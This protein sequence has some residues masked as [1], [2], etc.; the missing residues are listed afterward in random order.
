MIRSLNLPTLSQEMTFYSLISLTGMLNAQSGYQIS[1][2][3]LGNGSAGTRLDFPSHLENFCINTSH[4]YGFPIDIALN[5][6][7][8]PFYVAFR[9]QTFIRE[10][11]QIMSGTSVE[12]LKFK[13]GL[14]PAHL[15]GIGNLK[16]CHLCLEDDINEVGFGYW[17]RSHQLPSTLVCEKHSLLLTRIS[18]RDNGADKNT[19]L[20]PSRNLLNQSTCTENAQK[21][22]YAIS[23]ISKQVLQHTL[24][25]GFNPKQ[26]NNA[27]L[28]GLNQRGFL[29]ARGQIRANDFKVSLEQYFFVLKEIP[30]FERLLHSENIPYFLKL[31]RKPRGFYN[32]VAHI[33][34]IQFL[35]GT[36]EL[37]ESVYHWE[38]QFQLPLNIEHSALV[39]HVADD[40]AEIAQRHASGESLTSLAD[41]FEYDLSTLIRKLGKAGL[42]NIKRR[43]KKI[44]MEVLIQ[45]QELIK[46]GQSLKNIEQ[47]TNLSKSTIDRVLCSNTA[48]KKIWEI[49]KLERIRE[50]K[51]GELITLIASHPEYSKT[52]LNILIKST[53]SWLSKNDPEWLNQTY[54]SIQTKKSK[55]RR[56]LSNQRIDWSQRDIECLSALK[57]LGSF[58]VESWERLKPP[59]FLR[60]LPSLSFTPRLERLPRCQQWIDDQLKRMRL[61]LTR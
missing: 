9:P 12:T 6:T 51:R 27:Y 42:G 29:T 16:Y 49:K 5:H 48:L 14:P 34:L 31:I 24:P 18:L 38:S 36:W 47:L 57:M 7:V 40:L 35:F 26:L 25:N 44:T 54:R 20:L 11:V 58:E 15:K 45:I 4:A 17:H 23:V 50:S 30:S 28:H 59:I 55:C 3:L 37:F 8:L 56:Q 39:E 2:T 53:I 52:D 10:C 46:E 21:L 33:L 19:I 1:E 32:P 60:R 43:P 41:I 13:L 22:L 61:L